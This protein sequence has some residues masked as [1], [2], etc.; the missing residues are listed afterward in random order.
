MCRIICY[1]IRKR[2]ELD[3]TKIT[4]ITALNARSSSSEEFTDDRA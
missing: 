3:M 2:R 4:E 1:G